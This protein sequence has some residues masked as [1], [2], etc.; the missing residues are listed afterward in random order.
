MEIRNSYNR[1][2]SAIDNNPNINRA[3]TTQPTNN[4]R[5]LLDAFYITISTRAR[6]SKEYN[7]PNIKYPI[8]NPDVLQYNNNLSLTYK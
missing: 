2:D 1:Y 8:F 6:Q 5:K 7:D 3:R 4:V